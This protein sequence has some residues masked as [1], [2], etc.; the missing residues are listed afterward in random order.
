M[1]NLNRILSAVASRFPN[2]A[3]VQS[4][5]KTDDDHLQALWK[6][7][8][9]V[10]HDVQNIIQLTDANRPMLD[11]NLRVSLCAVAA[12]AIAWAY[13]TGMSTRT[14]AYRRIRRE[15]ERQT[16]LFRKGRIAFDV[17]SPIIDVRR[18]FR[19]LAEEI[20]EVAHAIDQVENHG[21][22]KSNIRM[23]LIQVAAVACAWLE[24]LEVQS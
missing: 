24:S 23:E 13:P 6:R 11:M 10:N 4:H 12:S 19:V 3:R 14:E 16:D 22:V 15:R 8:A 20:G 17:A 1:K 2:E 7:S 18:K 9:E 5:C 21:M